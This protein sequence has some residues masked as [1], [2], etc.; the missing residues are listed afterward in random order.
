MHT[1]ARS[2][3]SLCRGWP[4]ISAG[5]TSPARCAEETVDP[6]GPNDGGAKPDSPFE[7]ETRG[8][9]VSSAS[10]CIPFCMSRL[11]QTG[12]LDRAKG[13]AGSVSARAP[14]D[15]RSCGRFYVQLCHKVLS[16]SH[17]LRATTHR[18]AKLD[19][20]NYSNIATQSG[21][22]N[23]RRQLRRDIKLF[24]RSR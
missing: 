17:N 9:S 8:H 22:V 5:H 12:V 2:R 20:R 15:L 4:G 21:T 18:Q 7:K 16:R 1:P 24:S 13:R 10:A 6:L 3:F 11:Y 14:T 19:S 23:Q